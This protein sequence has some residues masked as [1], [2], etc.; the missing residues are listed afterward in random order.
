M[1]RILPLLF[2]GLILAALYGAFFQLYIRK[3]NVEATVRVHAGESLD[4]IANRMT[5]AGLVIHP[6]VF[7]LGARIFRVD[8]SIKAGYYQ[9]NGSYNLKEILMELT[10]GRDRMIQVTIPEGLNH[11]EI[12]QILMDNGLGTIDDYLYWFN[13]PDQLK[14][15]NPF[16]GDTLEGWLFP[17][18]YRFSEHAS[19]REILEHMMDQLAR[20]F[21]EIEQGARPGKVELTPLQIITLASLVEKETGAPEERPLIASVFLNR[22]TKNMKLDCDPTV[23]YALILEGR[24]DGNIRKADLEMDHPYNTYRRRGL[25][26]GPIANPGADAIR[27][28]L[29]PAET[30][31]LFFVSR[32]DGT[33]DFSATYREHQKKVNAYQVDYWR[34]KRKR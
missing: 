14:P 18:T 27:A 34:R 11:L 2:I 19:T 6:M 31:Y 16:P 10:T 30:K 12:F 1:K 13:H 4:L 5:R 20:T 21:S 23:I 29:H 26:P 9:F 33:H 22:L 28:V 32:N 24:W 3:H 17:N 25:P 8:R 15:V 7:R